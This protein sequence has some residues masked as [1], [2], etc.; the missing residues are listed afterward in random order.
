METSTWQ[1]ELVLFHRAFNYNC[2]LLKALLKNI[3]FCH[4]LKSST[5]RKHMW[6]TTGTRK[7]LHESATSQALMFC[8]ANGFPEKSCLVFYLVCCISLCFALLC[9]GMPEEG[10]E[11]VYRLPLG[12]N[13]QS[14]QFIETKERSS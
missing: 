14:M 8:F 3:V 7:E 9:F 11:I 10:I 6:R 4:H 5:H 13:G 2:I 12:E 1:F